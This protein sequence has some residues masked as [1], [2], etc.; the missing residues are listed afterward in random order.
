MINNN[1]NSY[2]E[3]GVDHINISMFSKVKLGKMLHPGYRKMFTFSD[4]G[5][6]KSVTNFGYWLAYGANVDELRTLPI[7]K[8]P[9][10]INDNNLVKNKQK[11][12]RQMLME[13]TCIK[14][15]A[16]P[17][18]VDE[19][20]NLPDT[21]VFL[22]YRKVKGSPVRLSTGFGYTAISSALYAKKTFTEIKEQL[23]NN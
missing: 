10:Y 1:P 12:H 20:V 11:N 16:Y 14:L 9:K 2:R 6:F 22:S 21:M 7:G 19:L 3:E 18:L 4:L 13:A 8:I 15:S 5:E 23:K 17:H